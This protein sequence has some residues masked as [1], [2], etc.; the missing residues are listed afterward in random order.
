MSI[1]TTPVNDMITITIF[2]IYI[3]V[4]FYF[5]ISIRK[6]RNNNLNNVV[7]LPGGYK[8]PVPEPLSMAAERV[9]IDGRKSGS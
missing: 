8:L 6:D 9:R 2:I 1:G 7:L 5:I 3:S 4:C